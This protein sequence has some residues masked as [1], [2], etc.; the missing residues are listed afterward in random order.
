MLNSST[1]F[2]FEVEL[3]GSFVVVLALKMLIY[4]K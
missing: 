1:F 2:L 4:A 3:K